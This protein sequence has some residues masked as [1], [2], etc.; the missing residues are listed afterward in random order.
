[1]EHSLHGINTSGQKPKVLPMCPVQNVTYVSGRA[2]NFFNLAG[3]TSS[4]R[5]SDS[6]LPG[7]NRPVRFGE[8]RRSAPCSA[9]PLASLKCDK[10]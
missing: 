7:F 1:T 5:S 10:C 3:M 6:R 2:S 4:F 8:N 9:P